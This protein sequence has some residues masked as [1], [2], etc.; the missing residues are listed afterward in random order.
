MDRSQACR[1]LG[2]DRSNTS[3]AQI[4]ERYRKLARQWHPDRFSDA[5]DKAQA[6]E[7]FKQIN[8]AYDYLKSHP[9]SESTRESAKASDYAN[10]SVAKDSNS[11]KNTPGKLYEEAAALGKL[12]RYEAAIELLGLA[13]KLSPKYAQA[14]R[15]RGFIRSVLGFEMSAEAD[16]RRAKAI[17]DNTSPTRSNPKTSDYQANKTTPQA[18]TQ[19]ATKTTTA[20][21]RNPN[22]EPRSIYLD[23]VIPAVS[24]AAPW[25][26]LTT[27]AAPQSQCVTF[28]HDRNTLITGDRS[29][30]ISLWSLKTKRE[31]V[32]FDRHQQGITAL[33]L[34][35]DGQILMS[36]SRDGSVNL[37]HV[38]S[39]TLIRSLKHDSGAVFSVWM[40]GDRR[41]VITGGE[42]QTLRVWQ[43]KDGQLIQ[44]FA[45][46]GSAIWAIAG[47]ANGT[48]F[49]TT[50]TKGELQSWK[51]LGKQR[52]IEA[53]KSKAELQ[54]PSSAI[55][56]LRDP[57]ALVCGNVTG[58]IRIWNEETWNEQSK[59]QHTIAAHRGMVRAIA[60]HPSGLQF[61]TAGED[62]LVRVWTGSE[63][64]LVTALA[65]HRGPVLDL[66]WNR[67]GDQL[68]SLGADG[69]VKLWQNPM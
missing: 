50:L 12:G 15:Y 19:Q 56:F 26:L 3:M 25:S 11:I 42:D 39:A 24:N 69:Q 48:T 4:K 17:D 57:A 68:A 21:P 32:R 14:Y 9:I 34:S 55:A 67:A 20:P 61:A 18:A 35:A 7:R 2:I 53:G 13:I 66:A 30:K 6:E 63:G 16:L 38:S 58:V 31:Y 8:G 64:R 36:A 10:S 46:Q 65:G 5:I 52:P 27:I 47:S 28:A 44:S 23:S 37:W 40:S 43:T 45:H 22:A 54:Y 1:I 62:G 29:G 33:S 49:A 59:P 51:I 41:Y 60:A